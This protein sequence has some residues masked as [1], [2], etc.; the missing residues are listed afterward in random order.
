MF[1]ASSS[2]SAGSSDA[3]YSEVDILD[4]NTKGEIVKEGFLMKKVILVRCD[5]YSVLKDLR[6]S[7]L[8]V[9]TNRRACLASF[10]FATG[11]SCSA[12]LQ[13]PWFSLSPGTL[14]L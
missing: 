10:W 14:L 8:S 13:L 3:G 4:T 12:I 9:R 2:D 1:I 5:V 6:N 7:L 11:L